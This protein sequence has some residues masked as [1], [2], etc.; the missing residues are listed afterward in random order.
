MHR[1][2]LLEGVPAK[3]PSDACRGIV[4][5]VG[6]GQ[7][8]VLER[9]AEDVVGILVLFA[10]C[11]GGGALALVG[12]WVGAGCRR[13]GRCGAAG[14]GSGCGGGGGS[15]SG[16]ALLGLRR[17]SEVAVF[18]VIRLASAVEVIAV[19][20]KGQFVLGVV[21]VIV[22][23]RGGCAAAAF[24]VSYAVI[25][26][27]SRHCF[28]LLSFGA[29]LGVDFVFYLRHD[30][31]GLSKHGGV[32]ASEHPVFALDNLRTL[33]GSFR[34]DSCGLLAASR[35]GDSVGAGVA[36][37]IG[38]RVAWF[39][40]RFSFAFGVFFLGRSLDLDLGDVVPHVDDALV[41]G[42]VCDTILVGLFLAGCGGCDGDGGGIR[43][44]AGDSRTSGW[45]GNGRSRST[46]RG[47]SGSRSRNRS[48][49]R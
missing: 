22:D 33:D 32:K 2:A 43:G 7:A 15:A 42:G 12:A 35:L 48:R 14:M 49:G 36:A 4:G 39:V 10:A 9:T 26:G 19:L 25:F 1:S 40:H 5:G 29:V 44:G 45:A 13:D 27:T 21:V 6:F 46:S 16:F 20:T 17:K 18:A 47:G 31:A 24:T 8:I 28:L 38:D 41:L 34:S 30:P 23:G 37:A 11:V 3:Y